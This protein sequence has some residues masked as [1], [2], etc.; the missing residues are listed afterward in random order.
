[1]NVNLNQIIAAARPNTEITL[2][3][4]EFEGPITVAKP[5]KIVGTTTTIWAKNA[6][7][8]IVKSAGVTL[9]N[10]RVELTEAS[11]ED[12]AIR[13]EFPCEAK[14]VEVL[15]AVEGFGAEDGFFDI[16]RTIQLGEFLSDEKNTFKLVVNV[17]EKT[18]IYCDM[19]EVSF[20]PKTLSRGRNELTIT[21]GGIS[22]QTYLYTEILFK[23]KFTRRI[24]LF[25]KPASSAAKTE[26][27]LIY[28]APKRDFSETKHV[29]VL[30]KESVPKSDVVSMSEN[31]DLSLSEIE[32]SRGMRVPLTKYLG[33]KF[34]V[35]FSCKDMPEKM[36][37]DPYVF[38]LD[39]NGKAL[40][41]SSLIFFGN[42]R[43]DNGEIAYFRQDGH[44]EIDLAKV[45]CRVKKITLVFSIYAGSAANN[46]SSVKNPRVSLW[47]DRERVSFVMRELAD[48]TTAVALEFYIYKGEWKISAVG[49]GYRDGMARLCESCGIHVEE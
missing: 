39:E 5:I 46:F 11:P 16:P 29:G 2:P 14:N 18:E 37:I 33:T 6:P 47:T 28:S 42:E 19:R 35:F 1:M 12:A 31:A 32:L 43:S 44:I 17:S 25:G 24:Y 30:P 9:E 8:L 34:S 7:A 41:D 10:L 15:G 48:V 26:N 38:L 21:V 4:G 23:T 49:S 40:G 22:A 20:E 3:A 27:K 45:D 13:A 36:E